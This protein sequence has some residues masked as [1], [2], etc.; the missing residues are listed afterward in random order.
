MAKRAFRVSLL[1]LLVGALGCGG[2]PQPAI[3]DASAADARAKKD[4]SVLDASTPEEDAGLGADASTPDLS[5]CS[6]DGWCWTHPYPQG[7]ALR[8]AWRAGAKDV[9][10][11]GTVGTLIHWDGAVFSATRLGVSDAIESMWGSSATDAWA[12]GE[13]GLRVHFDGKAWT[14]VQQGQP[15]VH[16]RA[17]HGSGPSDVLVVGDGGVTEHFNGSQ[18]SPMAPCSSDLRAV[19]A[20]SPGDAWRAGL[21]G[22]IE[23]WNGAAWSATSS[24]SS[25]TIGGL[26]ATDATHV[27]AVDATRGV[28]LGDGASW[29]LDPKSQTML[30][31]SRI[32][33]SSPSDIWLSGA[34]LAHW[35]GAQWTRGLEPSSINAAVAVSS[36]EAYA[37]G[38]Q[39]EVLQYGGTNWLALSR[40]DA[41]DID[42]LGPLSAN[43][44]FAAGTYQKLS[45]NGQDWTTDTFGNAG[46]T[47]ALC[48]IGSTEAWTFGG[49]VMHYNGASWSH[50]P[51]PGEPNTHRSFA[52][53]SNDVWASSLGSV[54][55]WNGSLWSDFTNVLPNTTI[56]A[57][58]SKNSSE[59]WLVGGGN[60]VM[61]YD[62][63]TWQS[64]PFAPIV[65]LNG[66]WGDGAGLVYVVGGFGGI[67]RWNGSTWDAMTSGTTQW[68]DDVY[69][70]AP[71]DVWVVGGGG[72]V[73]HYDGLSWTRSESGTDVELLRVRADATHLWAS[74]RHGAILRKK[75]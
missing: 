23:H 51:P 49:Y 1:P 68:L 7:N 58:W 9:W 34:G 39:G 3:V 57:I 2:D 46:G 75:R 4:A 67:Y 16:Y 28:L 61:H 27:W 44:G 43:K 62:G 13:R 54:T 35:D 24:G 29:T 15:S 42:A 52:S 56:H 59:A 53:A 38:E 18:W 31:L 33:G 36:T 41:S 71:N 73:L 65:S 64:V 45:W 72:T 6:V 10:F 30:Q 66:V 47:S 12:V 5:W 22:A 74:G 48:T 25:G 8:A 60:R 17:V 32:S 55:H 63:A 21:S 20:T 70:T 37:V 69:G 19:F 14:V 11:G 26:W 40:G 50:V